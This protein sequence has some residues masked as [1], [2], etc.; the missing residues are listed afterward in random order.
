MQTPKQVLDMYFL[1]TRYALLEIA[2]MFDRYDD[3][4]ARTDNAGTN[5]GTNVD[6]D[7]DTDTVKFSCDQRRDQLE[8]AVKILL[9]CPNAERTKTMLN[10]FSDQP[11][12]PVR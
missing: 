8:E 7:V 4:A 1:D 3:A 6:T 10:H 5:T 9:N 2:A 12:D 11:I